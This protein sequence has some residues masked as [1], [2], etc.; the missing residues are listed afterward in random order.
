MQSLCPWA[1]Q[2]VGHLSSAGVHNYYSLNLEFAADP[3]G[4]SIG[5]GG[6]PISNP[7]CPGLVL[8]HL[9]NMRPELPMVALHV[10]RRLIDCDCTET[11]TG[12]WHQSGQIPQLRS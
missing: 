4:T 12:R 10:R 7:E 2:N 3:L 9:A 11:S 6:L 1:V 8:D 5:G